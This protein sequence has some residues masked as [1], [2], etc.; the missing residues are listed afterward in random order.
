MNPFAKPKITDFQKAET[1][2][3]AELNELQRIANDLLN[4][5]RYRKFTRLF[6]DAEKNT[7]DL[8]MQYK[9]SDPYKY[10]A[11]VDEF[12]IELK[13]YRNLLKTITDLSNPIPVK[14]MNITQDFKSRI[15]DLM[16]K[17]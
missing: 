14:K 17:I 1:E 10:K 6:E 9:E 8:I 4:D 7:T 2:V 15:N 5:Q 13:V 3:K 11:K 16:E 12:L